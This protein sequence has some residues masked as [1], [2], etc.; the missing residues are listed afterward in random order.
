MS[1][2]G[3]K[4]ISEHVGIAPKQQLFC[5]FALTLGHMVVLDANKYPQ[6]NFAARFLQNA[7]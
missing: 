7:I 5:Y 6:N 1:V 3:Q 4:V 2:V